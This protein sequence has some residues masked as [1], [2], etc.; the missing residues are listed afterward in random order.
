MSSYP[1]VDGPLTEIEL[2]L[3]LSEG[4]NGRAVVFTADYGGKYDAIITGLDVPEAR[5][6][7]WRIRGKTEIRGSTVFNS[8]EPKVIKHPVYQFDATF[9]LGNG[10][11]KINIGAHVGDIRRPK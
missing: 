6:K 5:G 4:R 7:S 1:L 2:L 3:A 11:G 9:S 10:R 8:T